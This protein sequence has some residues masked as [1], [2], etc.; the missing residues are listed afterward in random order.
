MAITPFIS[1]EQ[2]ERRIRELGAQIARDFNGEELHVIGVLNGAFVFC[3]DLIRSTNLPIVVHFI[4]ASS[5]EGTQSSGRLNISL[6]LS[7][8]ITGKNILLVEDIIDTGLTITKLIELMKASSPKSLKVASLLYKPA[9]TVHKVDI[10][11]LGFEIEDKF[12][13]GFGLD[14][15]GRYRELPYIGVYGEGD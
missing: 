9:R 8:D 4:K 1:K 15:N 2:I 6:D 14:F 12:V 13:I 7:A 11:Y 5:Y 3:A 10:D